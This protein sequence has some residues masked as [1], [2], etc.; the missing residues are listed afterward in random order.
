MGSYLLIK[1]TPSSR[2]LRV[3]L[4]ASSSFG[5]FWGKR[6]TVSVKHLTRAVQRDDEIDLHLLKRRYG[7]ANI[8]FRIRR[9]VESHR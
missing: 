6:R 4:S 7:L 1:S 5:V 2:N 3:F 9:K 8:I